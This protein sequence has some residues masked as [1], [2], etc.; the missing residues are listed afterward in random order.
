M[1]VLSIIPGTTVDGPG[2]RT[3]VYLAGC[4]HRCPGCHN[5][6]SWDHDGGTEMTVDEI[7]ERIDR[8]DFDVTLTGGDPFFAPGQLL[9]LLKAVKE[10]GRNVW[11]YTGYTYEQLLADPLR[12]PL[13]EWIDVL[14][15]GPYVESLRS[16]SLPFRGSSNQRLIIPSLSSFG[17][18]ALYDPFG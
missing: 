5:P 15:D 11:C 8:E 3:S 16:V 13:L 14:V 6:Q 2:L 17:N 18:V 1:K 9:S 12:S 4:D 7:V 10:R